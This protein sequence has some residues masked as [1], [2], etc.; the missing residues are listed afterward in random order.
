MFAKQQLPANKDS[1]AVKWEGTLRSFLPFQ[2]YNILSV[3]SFRNMG[4]SRI[5]QPS[6]RFMLWTLVF[7]ILTSTEKSCLVCQFGMVDGCKYYST[8][9]CQRAISMEKKPVWGTD[10]RPMEFKT[11]NGFAN[12]AQ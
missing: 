9:E 3:T 5:K 2:I 4:L 8:H 11:L 1:R 7:I 10:Q 12:K 6:Y